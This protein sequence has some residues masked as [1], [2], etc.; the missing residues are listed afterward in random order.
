M[1]LS[2]L[3]QKKLQDLKKKK[4]SVNRLKYIIT[5]FQ[6]NQNTVQ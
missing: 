4:K 5:G 6:Q 2:E 1:D 3:Q